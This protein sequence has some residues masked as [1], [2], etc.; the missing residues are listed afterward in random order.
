[1]AAGLLRADLD[2]DLVIDLLFG[3]IHSRVFITH[4]S[5]TRAQVERLVQL[6]LEGIA[7]RP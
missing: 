1:M 5:L 3:P 6:V 7:A 4:R 2:V